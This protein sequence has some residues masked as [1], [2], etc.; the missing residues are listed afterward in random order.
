MTN[1]IQ[2]PSDEVTGR[3]VAEWKGWSST[4]HYV[5]DTYDDFQ[6]CIFHNG[7][8]DECYEYTKYIQDPRDD[9]DT[10]LE[11]LQWFVDRLVKGGEHLSLR[12]SLTGVWFLWVEYNHDPTRDGYA[13]TTLPTS[14][15][16]F[17]YAVV[18]LV[19]EILND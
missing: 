12:V 11:L 8:I 18:E 4:E 6:R 9:T 13:M 3:V 14:G 15:E 2:R 7:E 17:R 5:P 16:Q 19:A 1:Q 10:A